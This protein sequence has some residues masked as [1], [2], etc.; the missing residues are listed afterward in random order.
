[1]NNT[2][3]DVNVIQNDKK[4]VERIPYEVSRAVMKQT[5]VEDYSGF[6]GSKETRE[7]RQKLESILVQILATFFKK[8]LKISEDFLIQWMLFTLFLKKVAQF[9][10]KMFRF[11][12][13]IAVFI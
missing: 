8:L 2:E 12:K 9:Y 1:M 6:E 7:L 5:E 13:K 4:A 11:G 10:R 3:I